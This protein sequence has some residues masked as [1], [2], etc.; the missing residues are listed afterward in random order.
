MGNNRLLR[1]ITSLSPK[2]TRC[3]CTK[4]VVAPQPG[5]FGKCPRPEMSSSI[6]KGMD[7]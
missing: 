7:R 3:S 2:L 1:E 5:E 6:M 4:W